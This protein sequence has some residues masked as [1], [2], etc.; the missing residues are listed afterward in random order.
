MGR[1]GLF[2]GRICGESIRRCDED[3]ADE[4]RGND[5]PEPPNEDECFY[6][7]LNKGDAFIMLASC[8]H[9]GSANTTTDEY[10]L[11]FGTFVTRGYLRQEEN[12][13][14]L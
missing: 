10:R 3:G 9:G 2:R 7:E 6:A 14:H 1:R 4:D 5:R 13:S 12:V 8:Y 11:L